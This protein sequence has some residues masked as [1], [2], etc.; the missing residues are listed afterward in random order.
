MYFFDGSWLRGMVSATAV[1]W[2]LGCTSSGNGDD[3]NSAQCKRGTERCGCDN[4]ACN[5]GLACLSD[6]CVKDTTGGTGG[7][8]TG[9]TGGT[10]GGAPSG[11]SGGTPA[12]GSGS[13]GGGAA[14]AMSGVGGDTGAMSGT[15]GSNAGGTAGVGGDVNGGTSGGG[16]AGAAAGAG[17]STGGAGG[18][19]GSAGMSG[20]GGSAGMCSADLQTDPNNCGRCGKV[21]RYE[22]WGRCN[23]ACCQ[24]GA[25]LDGF[26]ECIRQSDGFV[27]CDDYCASI[28]E[29]CVPKGCGTSTY[30]A[31]A[32]PTSC[33]ASGAAVGTFQDACDAPI[34]FE[35][36]SIRCCCTDK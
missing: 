7:A 33:D 19:G 26:G 12:G 3:D 31:W 23:D 18:D 1:L 34:V 28:G 27:T 22:T 20:A 5:S 2:A 32:T 14:G 35:S 16:G 11:G 6:V 29:E 25:C 36:D 8:Q 10:T 24:N 17:G 21:C 13:T 30:R 9:G 15:G 4:G